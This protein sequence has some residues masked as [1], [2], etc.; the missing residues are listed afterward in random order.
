MIPYNLRK[1]KEDSTEENRLEIP[2]GNPEKA[3]GEPL[4]TGTVTLEASVLNPARPCTDSL[5]AMSAWLTN[6]SKEPADNC[7]INENIQR[8][9]LNKLQLMP[10]K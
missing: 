7:S 4:E 2:A 6:F 8:D 5:G 10:V 1:S 9:K 3:N